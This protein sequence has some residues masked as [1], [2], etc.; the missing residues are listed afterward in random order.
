LE[1]VGIAGVSATSHSPGDHEASL[2][3]FRKKTY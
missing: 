1:D 3:K 2:L